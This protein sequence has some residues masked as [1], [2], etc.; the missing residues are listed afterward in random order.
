MSNI[1]IARRY[2]A[3]LFEIANSA[4]AVSR[5]QDELNSFIEACEIQPELP[6]VLSS[7]EIPAQKRHAVIMTLAPL[8]KLSDL[9]TN[10]FKLL[11]DKR[12]IK[13][14]KE[15]RDAYV[16]LAAQNAGIVT[17]LVTTA[18]P[19][20]DADIFSQIE[21]AVGKM[22]HKQVRIESSVDPEIIGGVSIRVGDQIF[23]GSIAAELRRVRE[24]LKQAV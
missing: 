12:R 23:D 8:L 4:N 22:T 10:F 15:I 19:V 1:V 7:E 13:A 18:A 11:I 5:F 24:E 16:A 3:A 2:A 6:S 21:V 17:A 14:A 9:T 20:L